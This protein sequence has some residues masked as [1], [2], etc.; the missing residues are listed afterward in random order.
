MN[1]E[2]IK[3]GFPPCIITVEQRL[4]YY[5]ALDKAHTRGGYAD[6]LNLVSQA[7][8]EAFKPYWFLLSIEEL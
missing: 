4:E 2:L 7:V 3:A 1:L 8:R 6:F 5:Q